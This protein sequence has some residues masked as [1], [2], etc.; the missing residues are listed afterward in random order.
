MGFNHSVCGYASASELA[1]AFASDERW[2]VLA[3]ADF[4]DSNDLIDEIRD[5]KWVQFG[6]GYNGDGATYGPKLKTAFGKK[7]DLLALPTK[8]NP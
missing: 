1:A 2:H 3:F 7:K 4:C 8:P 6:A 5:K